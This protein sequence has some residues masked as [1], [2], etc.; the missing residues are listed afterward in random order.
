MV[1]IRYTLGF[2]AALA[3][4]APHGPLAA[5][6]LWTDGAHDPARYDAP[7]RMGTFRD[8]A[9]ERSGA[10]VNVRVLQWSGRQEDYVPGVGGERAEGSGFLIDPAGYVVTNHH[11]IEGAVEVRVRLSDGRELPAEVVGTDPRTDI[12]LLLVESADPLPF[13]PLGDSSTLRP[14]DWVIAIG[15]PFGYDH[16]VTAGIVSAL[17]RRDIRPGGRELYGDFIQVDAPINPGNSGGPLIDVHGN[18]IGVNTVVNRVAN[19]IAFAIPINMVKALLPQL[20]TGAVERSWLGARGGEAPGVAGARIEEVVPESPAA[21]AGLAPGD[22][23][24]RFGDEPVDGFRQLSW[25]AS[26]AGPGRLVRLEILRDGARQTLDVTLGRMPG[27]TASLGAPTPDSD[28]LTVWSARVAN[29]TADRAEALGLPDG[30]GV[31]VLAVASESPAD[32][33]GLR[34]GDVIVQ[35]GDTP[36][37][38]SIELQAAAAAF[39]AGDVLQLRVRRESSIVFVGWVLR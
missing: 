36:V 25:L 29:L 31:V 37:Q 39:G 6:Q 3:L 23:V 7:L 22:I 16:S 28:V 11:V 24:V 21:V 14:G 19:N 32:R 20:A 8:L 17:A 30:A 35:V 15:D 5:Q 38:S 9:A 34:E 10:V 13:A 2:V 18:V 33:A 12:G 27:T 4:L 26:I 1:S